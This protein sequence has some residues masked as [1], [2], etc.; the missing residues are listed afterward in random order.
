[1][2]CYDN[3][4][5][6]INDWFAFYAKS[7]CVFIDFAQTWLWSNLINGHSSYMYCLTLTVL[8]RWKQTEII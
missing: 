8:Q 3:G 7:A 5:M 1:M 6:S 4:F 2:Y